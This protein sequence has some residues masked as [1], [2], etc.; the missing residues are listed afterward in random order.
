MMASA[1]ARLQYGKDHEELQVLRWDCGWRQLKKLF[2]EACPAE[3]VELKAKFKALKE[4]M[5]PMVYE[6]GFLK[7]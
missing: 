2:E 6:L 4:K 3:F 7:K 5:L 1:S